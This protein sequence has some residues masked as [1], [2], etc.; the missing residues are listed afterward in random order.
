MP[1]DNN[2]VKLMCR[3][4]GALVNVVAHKSWLQGCSSAGKGIRQMTW[5]GS[6]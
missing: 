1:S 2:S 3:T 4:I 5:P 6:V